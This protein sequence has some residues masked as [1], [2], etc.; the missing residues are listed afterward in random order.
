MLRE[1]EVGLLVGTNY[2]VVL[3]DTPCVVVGYLHKIYMVIQYICE[4]FNVFDMKV[5]FCINH[6]LSN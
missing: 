1:I 6:I 4:V 5:I 3:G 2:V